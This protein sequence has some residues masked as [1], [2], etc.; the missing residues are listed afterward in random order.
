MTDTILLRA[1]E[2]A[3]ADMLSHFQVLPTEHVPLYEALGRTLAG[4]I[5][6]DTDVPPFANSAMDGYAVRAV[7][8]ARNGEGPVVLR[9][10]GEV[11]AGGV[12]DRPVTPGT[13]IRIM[14]GA[15]LPEGADTVVPFEETDEGHPD[16][17]RG[18]GQVRIMT[19]PERGSSVRVAGEDLRQGMVA[20]RRATVINPGAVGVL[21]TAGA[22]TVPVYRRP[23]VAI[24]ATG[25][26][27]STST[28]AL[29]PAR[30]ATRT[31]M[32]TPRKSSPLAVKCCVCRSRAIRRLMFV[33]NYRP[34]W[35]GRP[36]SFS[37][38]AV[39]PSATTTWSSK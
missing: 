16:T 23:R 26:G 1:V 32:P 17:L 27:R 29:V 11:P 34:H 36:I 21:A 22:A 9:I 39:S 33:R 28:S 31:A 5:L 6:A 18:S 10:V 3:Q 15:P 7:D 14:T 13:T 20:V 4:D 2:E 30:S 8:L 24:L 25:D 19:A 37:H 35:I 12:P 38:R